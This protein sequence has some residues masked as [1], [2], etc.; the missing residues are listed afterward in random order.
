MC[1][2][3]RIDADGKV[4]LYRNPLQLVPAIDKLEGQVE[5]K[6]PV[7]FAADRQWTAVGDLSGGVFSSVAYGVSADGAVVVGKSDSSSGTEAFRWTQPGGMVG[8]GDLP[9][10]SVLALAYGVSA[11]GSVMVGRSSSASGKGY[12]CS[13]RRMAMLSS[14]R[15]RRAARK[16]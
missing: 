1:H 14:P 5:R 4:G 8:L 7:R 10:G 15:S 12:S 3:L 16:S 2:A 11:D 6:G 9:G 13:R